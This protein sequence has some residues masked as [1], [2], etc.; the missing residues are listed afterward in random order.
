MN[1]SAFLQKLHC[2]CASCIQLSSSIHPL[3]PPPETPTPPP[4]WA[5]I[6]YAKSTYQLRHLSTDPTAL[7]RCVNSIFALAPITPQLNSFLNPHSTHYS[8]LQRNSKLAQS[9]SDFQSQ[10]RSAPTRTHQHAR[11]ARARRFDA[12]VPPR[13]RDDLPPARELV[14]FQLLVRAA[15]R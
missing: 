13:G 14:G 3:S 12:R 5:L 10:S 11:H 9:Q 15:G 4:C 7:A 8:N 2:S 6:V 1:Q